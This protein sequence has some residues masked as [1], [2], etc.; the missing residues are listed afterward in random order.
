MCDLHPACRQQEVCGD[1]HTY[2]RELPCVVPKREITEGEG[3]GE[4]IVIHSAKTFDDAEQVIFSDVTSRNEPAFLTFL[5]ARRTA[6]PA[7]V[8][9]RASIPARTSKRS[10]KRLNGLTL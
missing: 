6:W 4:V 9:W 2:P 3:R 5:G 7:A 10:T 8:I 1:S